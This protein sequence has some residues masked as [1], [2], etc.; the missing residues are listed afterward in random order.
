MLAYQREYCSGAVVSALNSLLLSFQT[1]VELALLPP[2]RSSNPFGMS[3]DALQ[4]LLMDVWLGVTVWEVSPNPVAGFQ[5]SKSCE[6]WSVEV[7]G[8]P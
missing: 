7:V 3:L 6:F 1:P 2:V 5:S 4:K 8:V